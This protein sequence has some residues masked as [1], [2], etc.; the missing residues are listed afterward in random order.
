M[1]DVGELRGNEDRDSIV[2]TYANRDVNV[3]RLARLQPSD[4]NV[5]KEKQNERVQNKN[6]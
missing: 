4:R 2:I 5:K 3:N 6:K 1:I